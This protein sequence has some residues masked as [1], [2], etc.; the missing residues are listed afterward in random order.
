MDAEEIRQQI[1][2]LTEHVRGVAFQQNAE[3][4]AGL[5]RY[6]LPFRPK[7]Y[8]EIGAGLW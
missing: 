5:I 2:T 4:L 8:L 6:L 7:R 3:E 1:R